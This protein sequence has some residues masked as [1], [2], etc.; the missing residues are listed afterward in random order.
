M[1]ALF[2]PARPVNSIQQAIAIG[3]AAVVPHRLADEQCMLEVLRPWRYL[4]Y[5][6]HYACTVRCTA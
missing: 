5:S 3:S 2:N 1:F 6:V 4:Q